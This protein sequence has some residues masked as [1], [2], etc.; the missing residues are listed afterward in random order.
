MSARCTRSPSGSWSKP[1]VRSRSQETSSTWSVYRD[2][3]EHRRHARRKPDRDGRSL[4]ARHRRSEA[5]EKRRARPHQAA[6]RPNGRRG[7][8]SRGN[9]RHRQENPAGVTRRRFQPAL[10]A[11]SR[12]RHHAVAR[13]R[14]TAAL[15]RPRARP[16]CAKQIHPIAERS[17]QIVALGRW[18]L[19]E[20]CEQAKKWVDN[21]APRT[22]GVNVSAY[23]LTDPQLVAD[24][25]EALDVTGLPA[26]LL[27]LEITESAAV[28]DICGTV[29]RLNQLRTLGVPLSLDDFGTGYSSLAM[30]RQLPITTLKIDRS[31]VDRLDGPN[32][33]PDAVLIEAVIATAHAYGLTVVA[34]GIER[35][36]QLALLRN[37]VVT[38]HKASVTPTT[39]RQ[40]DPMG[41]VGR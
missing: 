26:E 30:L 41:A 25:D 17:A 27:R 19:F 10:P 14:S 21:G 18:A 24:V 9:R 11:A 2:R 20:A 39:T 32:N 5:C 34:E 7:R 12:H 22:V 23:Q 8:R 1:S 3:D 38:P 33:Y 31:F 16:S 13:S 35:P 29:G 4:T 36:A 6:V 40:R 37:M 28:S 15:D